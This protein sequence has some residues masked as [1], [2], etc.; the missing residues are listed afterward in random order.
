MYSNYCFLISCGPYHTIFASVDYKSACHK[1]STGVA[2]NLPGR[3]HDKMYFKLF[4][5]LAST[6]AFAPLA[7]AR[8]GFDASFPAV[9]FGWHRA[10]SGKKSFYSSHKHNAPNHHLILAVVTACHATVTAGDSPRV[11]LLSSTQTSCLLK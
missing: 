9:V 11:Q 5:L 8:N 4:C 10:L 7:G 2:V 1:G 6:L 3:L